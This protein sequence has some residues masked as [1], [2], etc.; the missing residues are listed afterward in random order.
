MSKTSKANRTDNLVPFPGAEPPRRPRPLRGLAIILLIAITA[1]VAVGA[2]W[3]VREVR[4][5][6]V[7][8]IPAEVVLGQAALQGGERMLLLRPGPIARRVEA[9][10]GVRAAEVHKQ[11]SGTLVVAVSERAPLVRIEGAADL[12]ADADGRLFVLTETPELPLLVVQGRLRAGA[13]LRPAVGAVLTA[14]AG[15]PDG[16]R[17]RVRRLVV[18]RRFEAQLDDGTIVRFGDGEHLD[19]K[20]S[21]AAAVLEAAA[22][23]QLEYVDV[24]VPSAP[25]SRERGAPET[26]PEPTPAADSASD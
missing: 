25:V 15:F 24:R 9:I 14:F 6:G 2:L 7:E 10:P 4:V 22:G 3:R 5:A 21:A 23:Q 8:R 19:A 18:D 1:L 26:T 20:G 12:V 16:L 17:D 13:T 11:L